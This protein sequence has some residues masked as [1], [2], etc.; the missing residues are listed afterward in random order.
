MKIIIS[1]V[2]GTEASVKRELSRL[3]VTDAKAFDSKFEVVG[4]FELLA[5]LC[6]WLRCA[7]RVFIELGKFKVNNFDELFDNVSK[8]DFSVYLK[9]YTRVLLDGNCVKS[10]IMAIK[11]SGGVIKKAIMNNLEKNYGTTSETGE[12]IKIYFSIINDIC[13]ILLDACGN[14]LHKRGY[15]KLTYSAP[16]KETLACSMLDLSIYSPKKILAD[17]F[18]GSGT[19]AIEAAMLARNIAPGINRHFDFEKFKNYP[20]NLLEKVKKDAKNQEIDCYP[21]IFASDINPEAIELAK[22][23]AKIAGVEKY[24][25]FSVLDMKDFKSN[26]EYGIIISNPPYG[27]RLMDKTQVKK[28]YADFFVMF[29]NLKNWSCYILT[30]YEEFETIFKRKADKKRKLYNAKIKCNYYTF[31]GKKPAKTAE[32]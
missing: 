21:K 29:K 27:D 3:G 20:Q 30:D 22:Q 11:S 23:N 15:R 4:D 13:W 10:K 31:L 24:I 6:V 19:I 17:V 32:N 1:C 8:I 7:D 14:G 28:L 16:L 25:N 18:C 2:S 12:T 5:K 9:K 26:D